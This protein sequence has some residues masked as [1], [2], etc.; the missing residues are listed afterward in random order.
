MSLS[1]DDVLQVLKVIDQSEV[2]ELHVELGDLK[3]ALRTA[4]GAEAGAAGGLAAGG[5]AA[6]G[7]ATGGLAAA[8]PPPA[9]TAAAAAATAGSAPAAPAPAPTAESAAI[10]A[11]LVPI[12]A[13]ILGTF[14]RKPAPDQPPFVEEGCEI[15]AETVV[16]LI[17]VMKMFNSVK[18]GVRGRIERVCVA[19][20][21]LVEYGQTLFLVRPSE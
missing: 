16:C 7:L 1:W 20:A 11:G 18:A 15:E 2:A 9:A 13:S 8:A 17:E 19:D 14:Y 12:K 4:R 21:Q 6:G 3:L 5:L 10:P